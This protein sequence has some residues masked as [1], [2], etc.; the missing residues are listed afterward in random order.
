MRGYADE[1][2][3]IE[4]GSNL[5]Y[6]PAVNLAAAHASG[7]YLLTLNP[8]AH[9]EAGCLERMAAV[10][11]S[12]PQILLVGAQIL[13]E[14]GVTRNAGANPMHPTGH[15]AGG[16]LRR[17]ARAGRAAR[18]GRRLGRLLLDPP[19]GLPR[20]SAASSMSSS[21]STTTP[22]WAGAR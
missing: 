19:R 14:D 17:A 15:L 12:D 9:V 5:G 21:S 10:A 18:C 2:K 22:T 13:L 11:D 20:D 8:D 3:V 7:D 16:R 6:A 4:P 1:V